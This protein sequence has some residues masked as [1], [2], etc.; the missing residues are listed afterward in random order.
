MTKNDILQRIVLSHNRL[1]QIMV[2]GEGAIL[3]GDS[4]RD[5]RILVKDLQE[6]IEK[7]DATES[8]GG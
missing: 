2:N 6:D 5:L 8:C 7:K 4:L 1:S 3:M